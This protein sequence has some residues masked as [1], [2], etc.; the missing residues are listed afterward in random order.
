MDCKSMQKSFII[1]SFEEEK[2]SFPLKT[3]RKSTN[4]YEFTMRTWLFFEKIKMEKD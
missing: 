1:N 3:A 4:Y 2:H